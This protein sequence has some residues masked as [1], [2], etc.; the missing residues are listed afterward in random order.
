MAEFVYEA[1]MEKLKGLISAQK[2]AP[3]QRLPS[4]KALA[5]E[6]GVGEGSV[7]EAIRILG[8]MRVL[9]VLHGSGIY[10]NEELGLDADLAAQMAQLEA[11]SM[12]DLFEARRALEPE[13]A[14]LAAERAT[15]EE[16]ASMLEAA[17]TMEQI[18]QRGGDFLEVD[19]SFHQRIAAAARSPVLLRML[20]AIEP[21][22]LDSR[23]LTNRLPGVPEKSARYHVLIAHAIAGGNAEQ[24]RSLMHAH[25][26]DALH[27]LRRRGGVSPRGAQGG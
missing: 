17:L 11:R 8:S 5:R 20:E 23:R 3:G 9:R 12:F 22:L 19:L 1:V 14:A 27:E 21:L 26:S 2:Y 16:V 15:P 4:I 7:R 10:I 13:L 6:M 24:A 25:M 18:V